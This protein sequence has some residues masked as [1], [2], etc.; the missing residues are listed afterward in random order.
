MCGQQSLTLECALGDCSAAIEQ[1]DL[2]KAVALLKTAAYVSQCNCVV[3][4]CVYCCSHYL[5]VCLCIA[6][7]ATSCSA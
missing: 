1:E 7:T 6:V 3:V 4:T 2:D 5:F